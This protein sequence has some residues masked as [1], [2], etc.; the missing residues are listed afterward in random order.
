MIVVDDG[1]IDETQQI[2]ASF[3]D[4]RIKYVYQENQGANVARNRGIK[5]S[6]GKYFIFLDSD[7]ALESNHI[8]RYLETAQNNPD[9]N[10]YGPWILGRIENGELRILCEKGK[11]PS[12]DLLEHWIGHWWVQTCCILWPRSTVLA[13]NGWDESLHANQDGDIAM[14]ALINNFR[15]VYCESAPKAFIHKHPDKK[16]IT[17]TLNTKTY[18]SKYKVLL[19]VES[20]LRERKNLNS[21]YRRA[22]GL[23]H[24]HY[25]EETWVIFPD[26]S[27][28]CFQKYKELHGLAKP[29][30]TYMNWFFLLLLGLQ[31][32]KKL[33]QC[34]ARFISWR[35]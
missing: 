22:L 5:E 25:A 4:S 19:K 11:C 6:S 29:P 1:S 23:K 27:N 31:K 24:L 13:L 15:F 32:K 2:V 21:R 26:F 9:A 7:D 28:K 16:S 12:E 34:I 17:N 35:L 8:E 33:A 30:G 14:R 20:L 10:I 3:N 18:E